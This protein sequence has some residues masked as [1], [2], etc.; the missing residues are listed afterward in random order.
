M[1]FIK[2]KN[3][4]K[5]QK[6]TSVVIF[7][8]MFTIIIG[9]AALTIDI[10]SVVFEKARLSSAVDAAALAGAQELIANSTNTQN[11]VKNYLD[12]NVMG[13]Q[14]N[15]TSINSSEHSVKVTAAKRVD[16]FFARILGM[17]SQDIRAE[18]KA[19]VENISSLTGVRPLGIIQQ[20]FSY[21]TQYT[22]KQGASDGTSGNYAAIDLW[23]S[24]AD[25]Y[26]KNLLY[27]YSGTVAIGNQIPTKTGIVAEK[28]RDSINQL[29]HNCTH[30][31]TYEKYNPNCPRIIQMPVVSTFDVSG[32]KYIEILG[33]ATFF[34]EGVIYYSE[35]GNGVG[36]GAGVGQADIV[37]RFI[38]EIKNGQTS[39]TI[40]DYGTY[41]I[42]LVK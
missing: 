17:S 38:T 37:G 24:G 29:I 41:G 19:K 23:G 2:V 6:G 8:L 35:N 3:I 27:G 12:K 14:E 11:I 42:R 34:L 26:G 1:K 28:T 4:C 20:T 33:F 15:N 16:Y 25:D 9:F 32:K 36:V 18:A 30:G 13:L 10:G 21:G 40:S 22:L 5:S 39:G 7:A 31:C